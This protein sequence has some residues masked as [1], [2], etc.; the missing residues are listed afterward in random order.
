MMIESITNAF[1]GKRIMV[2]GDLMLDHYIRGK[3][4]RISPEAPV[5]VVE[6]QNEEYRLGGAAN[7]ALNI[8][9]LSSEPIL[10]G[11]V[12]DDKHAQ[13]MRDILSQN[14]I[15]DFGLFVDRG[16]PTT[17]KTRINAV[18]QQIVRLDYES[19][20][21]IAGE[22]QSSISSWIREQIPSCS[23]L[24]IEDYN[25]GLLS[26]AMISDLIKL[27]AT[28]D[29]PVAVDPKHRHFFDYSGVCIF[30]PNFQEMQKNLGQ[31][32]ETEDEFFAAAYALKERINAT[33]M[34][35]TRGSK[36]LYV[37]TQNNAPLH[38]PTFAKEVYDVSGA[39]DTVIS[40]LSLAI[41]SGC[42]IHTAATIANHA[43][44][45]VCG[46]LGTATVNAEEIIQSYH[47][48]R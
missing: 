12:G 29:V 10:V 28:F 43:A 4:D 46:K 1:N 27:A 13:I 24:I 47:D 36:G 16:R 34:V 11:V 17:V 31:S 45:V 32:F 25:K 44:G 41:A 9:S 15:D 42:D 38:I 48:H 19:R 20:A 7:V 14:G 18:N 37:F 30:K 8:R 6:V 40:V 2:V 23:A 21:D 35:V 26:S 39:G 33:Y 3:V 5:P 22:L